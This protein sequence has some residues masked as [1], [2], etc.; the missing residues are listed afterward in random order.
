MRD[1]AILMHVAK[2]GFCQQDITENIPKKTWKDFFFDFLAPEDGNVRLSQNDG[3]E[4]P[5]NTA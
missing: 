3:V 5:I 1:L 2:T 4:L